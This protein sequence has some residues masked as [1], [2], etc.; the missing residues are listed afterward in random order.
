MSKVILR[1]SGASR[2]AN[3]SLTLVFSESGGTNPIVI[4]SLVWY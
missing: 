3:Q 1:V 4:K 2:V